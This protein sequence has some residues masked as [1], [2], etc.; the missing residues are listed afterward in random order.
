MISTALSNTPT[1]FRFIE[2]STKSVLE[3]EL[4]REEEK[5]GYVLSGLLPSMAIPES[6]HAYG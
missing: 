6:L 1:V 4:L 3:G 2:E 5:G